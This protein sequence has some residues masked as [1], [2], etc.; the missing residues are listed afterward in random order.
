MSSVAFV[1]VK[2]GLDGFSCFVI[3]II[4]RRH[5][6]IVIRSLLILVI[7][8][9]HNYDPFTHL[10]CR[11]HHQNYLTHLSPPPHQ[12]PLPQT[13]DASPF[14]DTSYSPKSTSSSVS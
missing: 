14:L 11:P 3:V 6:L 13:P 2:I 5:R 10:D 8:H 4:K 1:L 9:R 7:H 12:F